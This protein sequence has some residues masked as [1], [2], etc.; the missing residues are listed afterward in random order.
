MTFTLVNVMYDRV[1][2]L[3]RKVSDLE[4]TNIKLMETNDALS[5]INK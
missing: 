2:V 1:K 3:E 5:G 4:G